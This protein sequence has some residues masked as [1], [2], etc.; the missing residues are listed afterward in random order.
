MYTYYNKQLVQ[1]INHTVASYRITRKPLASTHC[2]HSKL[3]RKPNNS[4][5]D[6]ISSDTRGDKKPLAIQLQWTSFIQTLWDLNVFV[7][8]IFPFDCIKT[9]CLLLVAFSETKSVAK[10]ALTNTIILPTFY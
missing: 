3:T 4:A 10:N 1:C 7:T 2:S 9:N 5:W 8:S 6:I